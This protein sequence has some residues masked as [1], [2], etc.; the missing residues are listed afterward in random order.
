VGIG[1]ITSRRQVWLLRPYR[2]H[3][4]GTVLSVTQELATRLVVGNWATF[5][6]PGLMAASV[7]RHERAVATHH[8]ETRGGIQ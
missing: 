1:S 6:E 7:P 3:P 2:G 5:V 4:A 8:A